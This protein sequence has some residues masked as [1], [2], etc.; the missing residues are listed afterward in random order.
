MLFSCNELLPVVRVLTYRSPA[1]R[2]LTLKPSNEPCR[3]PAAA[4]AAQQYAGT[5]G[6]ILLRAV[7]AGDEAAIVALHDRYYPRLFRFLHRLT[8]DYA[9]AEEVA[10]DVMVAAWRG[11]D[12]FRGRS[13]AS[14][15]LLG[16]AY[17]LGLKRLRRRRLR[18]MFRI[19]SEDAGVDQRGAMEAADL[20]ATALKRLSI[21]D[22]MMIELVLYLGLTYREVAEVV[23]C[24]VNTA[25]TRVHNARR[26]L[27]AILAELGYH[28]RGDHGQR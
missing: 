6:E 15:W 1:K 7:A 17:R 12:S 24:P 5:S 4:S 13:K 26:R 27:Q 28:G 25:K 8:G 22:R 18:T 10:N 20:V 9:L 11:A 21:N 3:D 14:T 16:V 19:G 2:R 23:D